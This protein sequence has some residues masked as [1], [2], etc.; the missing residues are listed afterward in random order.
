MSRKLRIGALVSG[1]GTNLQAILDACKSHRING[2]VVCVG[3]DN[4]EAGGLIR[5]A[6]ASIPTFLIPYKET[7]ALLKEAYPHWHHIAPPDFN[8]G[9]T[10]DKAGI[11]NGN[12]HHM[13]KLLVTKAACEARLL[14]RIQV[15][16]IDVLVLAGFMRLLSP[17]FLD[18]FQP[19][20][21]SP[22]VLNIHPALLPAFP[23]T[24]GY[25]D[26]WKHGVKVHGATVHFVD[27]GEDTGPIIGQSCYERRD[28]DTI[29]SFSSR[30]LELEWELYVRCLK[31]FCENRLKVEPGPDGN[32]RIV[33]I[34][35]RKIF[36]PR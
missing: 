25:G 20:P 21:L 16:E 33:T 31:L 22:R 18:H 32:R 19:D 36:T 6:K 9:T 3:S 10:L 27:Y 35:P 12:S 26:A 14:K 24:D 30:G 15:F 8:L 2:E 29:E 13:R 11:A 7:T 17:Y 1:G 34:L 28:D 23:G 4:P 5:A